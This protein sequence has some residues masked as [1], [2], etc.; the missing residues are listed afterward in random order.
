MWGVVNTCCWFPSNHASF[1]WRKPKG[2]LTSPLRTTHRTVCL[3]GDFYLICSLSFQRI[4]DRSEGMTEV[5]GGWDCA[6]AGG[7]VSTK[8]GKQCSALLSCT[9]ASEEGFHSKFKHKGIGRER[10]RWRER[11]EIVRWAPRVRVGWGRM[12]TEGAKGRASPRHWESF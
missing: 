2:H 8:W 9:L 4:Q 3:K 6:F 12:K 7:L 10:L 5:W 11:Q 1:W